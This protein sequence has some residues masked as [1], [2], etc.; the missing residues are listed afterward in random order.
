MVSAPKFMS[1]SGDKRLGK[2]EL[3]MESRT[4]EEDREGVAREPSQ[5]C[6]VGLRDGRAVDPDWGR[7]HPP[8]A[9]P[10]APPPPPGQEPSV[11][12][13][14]CVTALGKLGN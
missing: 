11:G 14:V 5:Q 13:G 8:P 1:S 12:G 9:P 3:D 10:P 4:S 6:R 7:H 2:T